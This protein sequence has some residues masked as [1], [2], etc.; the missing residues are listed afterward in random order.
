MRRRQFELKVK[1]SS[2]YHCRELCLGY[3]MTTVVSEITRLGGS[4]STLNRARVGTKISVLASKSIGSSMSI[5]VYMQIGSALLVLCASGFVIYVN[6]TPVMWGSMRRPMELILHV[7]QSLLQ[8][9]CAASSCCMWKICFGSLGSSVLSR[10]LS[11]PTLKRV[12][13]S[14]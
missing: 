7:L 10:I 1:G 5:R 3:R 13:P 2:E 8:Q 4:I 14:P 6:G 12:R 9:A 11:I